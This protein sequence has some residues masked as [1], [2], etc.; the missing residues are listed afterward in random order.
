MVGKLLKSYKQSVISPHNKPNAYWAFGQIIIYFLLS[1]QKQ[2]KMEDK[3]KSSE[4]INSPLFSY[5][6]Y[7]ETS[8]IE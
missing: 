5:D 1:L 6:D 3:T 2:C 8:I 4:D 7:A